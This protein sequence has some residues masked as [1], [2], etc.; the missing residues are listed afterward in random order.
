MGV[1]ACNPSTW[2]GVQGQ[3][4]LYES[5]FKETNYNVEQRTI[6]ISGQMD[7]YLLMQENSSSST[8]YI[9]LTQANRPFESSVSIG[10]FSV[11]VWI[12]KCLLFRNMM[13]WLRGIHLESIA[14]LFLM[15]KTSIYKLTV[16]SHVVHMTIAFLNLS[17]P[18]DGLTANKIT[19]E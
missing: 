11:I 17:G 2:E 8:G 13:C 7:D 9:R 5:C 15:I 12:P 19:S 16:Q 4:G 3:P 18:L 14:I 1:L 10:D 6:Q